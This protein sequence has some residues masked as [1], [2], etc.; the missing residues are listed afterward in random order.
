MTSTK[1][2]RYR[3]KEDDFIDSIQVGQYSLTQGESVTMVPV[4]WVCQVPSLSRIIPDSVWLAVISSFCQLRYW[5]LEDFGTS[6]WL[7]MNISVLF[8]S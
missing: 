5:N 6:L 3:P 8:I 1:T 2:R 4:L 7:S